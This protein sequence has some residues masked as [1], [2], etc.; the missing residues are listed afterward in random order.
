MNADICSNFILA[1]KT[2]LADTF[3]RIQQHRPLQKIP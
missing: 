3:E 1:L 2:P